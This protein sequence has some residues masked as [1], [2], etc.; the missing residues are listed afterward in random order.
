M[1][2]IFRHVQI[3]SHGL[4]PPDYPLKQL[5][6]FWGYKYVCHKMYDELG[7]ITQC[8]ICC[9]TFCSLFCPDPK[10]FVLKGLFLQNQSGT[11]KRMCCFKSSASLLPYLL[12]V[13]AV[14]SCLSRHI[15]ILNSSSSYH[16]L[17]IFKRNLRENVKVCTPNILFQ[18]PLES[19]FNHHF[20]NCWP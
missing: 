13:A 1:C 17:H 16:A 18:L 6:Q 8:T 11:K 3:P 2:S 4:K 14:P 20:L 12:S 9:T 15:Q 7:D 5:S 10:V 19:T